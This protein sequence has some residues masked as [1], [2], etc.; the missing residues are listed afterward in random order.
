MDQAAK[1]TLIAQF[2]AYLEEM[3]DAPAPTPEDDTF[4]LFAELASKRDNT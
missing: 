1:E 2:R 4:S 3:A